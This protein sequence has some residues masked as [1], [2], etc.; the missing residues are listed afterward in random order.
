MTSRHSAFTIGTSPGTI[1]A[2]RFAACGASKPA[3]SHTL[4]LGRAAIRGT[5]TASPLPAS[6]EQAFSDLLHEV[7]PERGVRLR[8]FIGGKQFHGVTSMTVACFGCRRAYR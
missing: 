1:C 6:L 5:H 8:I 2:D 7:K 3:L 4:H